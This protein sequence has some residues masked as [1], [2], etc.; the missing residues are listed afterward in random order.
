MKKKLIQLKTKEK[1]IDAIEEHGKQ[2]VE[3]NAFAKKDNLLLSNQKE[4]F[5]KLVSERM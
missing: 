3:S 5:Y 2:L 4:I 1:Q